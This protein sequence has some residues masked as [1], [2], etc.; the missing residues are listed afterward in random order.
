[1][2]H[3]F[4]PLVL[5]VCAAAMLAA[6]SGGPGAI[7][8]SNGSGGGHA[9]SLGGLGGGG[10]PTPPPTTLL[11]PL[12]FDGAT[13]AL[14]GGACAATSIGNA[15]DGATAPQFNTHVASTL[16]LPSLSLPA[17]CALPYD[18]SGSAPPV[19]LPVTTNCYVIEYIGSVGPFFLQGPAQQ[20]GS[21]L[22]F[23]PAATQIHLLVGQGYT[24]Y[25]GV[26]GTP[27]TPAPTPAPTATPCRSGENGNDGDHRGSESRRRH[28][29]HEDRWDEGHNACGRDRDG[30]HHDD[31]ER[32]HH[33]D[34]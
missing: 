29:M 25:L 16:I 34:D 28:G 3:G 17:P 7:P 23:A 30:G 13:L 22:V 19:G 15:C 20:V 21:Q 26:Q 4:R 8:T 24:F 31:G 2:R 14:S 1:M 5:V 32:H 33:H 12:S 27:A 10:L 18:V 9:L 11:A 6:C